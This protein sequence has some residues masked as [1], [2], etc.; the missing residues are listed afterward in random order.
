MQDT[1]LQN[2]KQR[3]G[4]NSMAVAAVLL[5]VGQPAS[6]FI[7]IADV[8]VASSLIPKSKY[9]IC[10]ISLN[11]D[12][13]FGVTKAFVD[14]IQTLTQKPLIEVVEYQQAG[15][16]PEK[17]LETLIS[18]HTKCDG[19][20]ISGHHTGAFGGGRASG[21]L[22]I[23]FMER[24]TCDTEKA[25]WFNKINS[26]WLQ[27]CRTLG[28]PGEG[29]EGDANLADYHA[30]RVGRVAQE[31]GLETN[32]AQLARE[33][34]DL[35]DLQTPYAMRFMKSFPQ[36]R[37]FGWT[38]TAPGEKAESEKSLPFHIHNVAQLM[39][40]T[41]KKR[42]LSR[43]FD[44][45]LTVAQAEVYLDAIVGLLLPPKS[46]Q[47]LKAS[48]DGWDRHG[49]P[50]LSEGIVGFDNPD[51]ASMP[52]LFQN[53]DTSVRQSRALEC[54]VRKAKTKPE[55]NAALDEILKD[56]G[57]IALSY[58]T[59]QD[60]AFTDHGIID[61]S[62][63]L[64]KLRSNTNFMTFLENKVDNPSASLVRRIEVAGFLMRLNENP[65]VAKLS[66]LK[67]EVEAVL[68]KPL[69]DSSDYNLRD[70]KKTLLTTAMR[71]NLI[72]VSDLSALLNRASDSTIAS[73][74]IDGISY[75]QIM[76][77]K[78]IEDV[79][80][81]V[82][83]SPFG[84][85][86]KQNLLNET[87]SLRF[88]TP[89]LTALL[90]QLIEDRSNYFYNY[91]TIFAK[92]NVPQTTFDLLRARLIAEIT[93]G[94]SNYYGW[95]EFLTQ[96]NASQQ[97]KDLVLEALIKKLNARDTESVRL[98]LSI[99][100]VYR[101]ELK[102]PAQVRTKLTPL[103]AGFESRVMNS[104]TSGVSSYD[105]STYVR[106]MLGESETRPKAQALIESW[107][108]SPQLNNEVLETLVYRVIGEESSAEIGFL[109]SS[110]G[111]YL[112]RKTTSADES[113]SLFEFAAGK[114]MTLSQFEAI[115]SALTKK[116]GRSETLSLIS[117]MTVSK[118]KGIPL[119]MKR[120][121]VKQ[122]S[123]SLSNGEYKV[124][125][126]W[127]ANQETPG[128]FSEAELELSIRGF[129]SEN[130]DSQLGLA[131][132]IQLIALKKTSIDSRKQQLLDLLPRV[133]DEAVW[134]VLE[135][136]ESYHSKLDPQLRNWM[137]EI[138]AK[139]GQVSKDELLKVRST[140]IA[141]SYLP[142]ALGGTVET[143]ID[144]RLAR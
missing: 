8:L 137:I 74:M 13:E 67:A 26:L 19:L 41:E 12:K 142:E 55:M 52:P 87:A 143:A 98:A 37:L 70:Y 118:S 112:F 124:M 9:R 107:L 75:T 58:Y 117:F 64:N 110:L 89:R 30:N 15:E 7:G 82:S 76:S 5:C 66:K 135:L 104:S 88:T 134:L 77:R 120:S 100:S 139:R 38:R 90:K 122:L 53:V 16:R 68:L 127:Y 11:N 3:L 108:K 97:D 119:E 65:S 49:K 101:G 121:K 91:S 62:S 130:P 73:G 59:I 28:A 35:L 79:I 128:L 105:R 60:V 132:L 36:A 23:E 29:V 81:L 40:P 93:E 32:R 51:L 6:A 86:L 92:P 109:P 95:A 1:Q 131:S 56:Q 138:I 50:N 42:L 22:S 71:S 63:V 48:L 102:L 61:P 85:D 54:N 31:D 72:S 136:E 83:S 144:K 140:L 39:L 111:A 17:T 123:A 103:L 125:M 14:R 24:N 115:E 69:A 94:K 114:N 106:F 46:V 113:Y 10:Y 80:S 84:K 47:S 133:G 44:P 2:R 99:A 4:F 25:D 126:P 18:T 78:Q 34:S 45:K 33:F 20:V 96:P 57:R 21:S 141:Q 43:P 116:F 27:G 129:V